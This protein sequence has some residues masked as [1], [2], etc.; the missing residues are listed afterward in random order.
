MTTRWPSTVVL[1]CALGLAGCGNTPAS[2]Q[3]QNP[4]PPAF[5]NVETAFQDQSLQDLATYA[6]SLV[7]AT[8]KGEKESREPGDV[9]HGEGYIGRTLTLAI[10]RTLWTQDGAPSVPEALDVLDWGWLVHEDK[11]VPVTAKGSPK[12][13]VG[14]TYLFALTSRDDKTVVMSSEATFLL[15][16]ENIVVSAGQD[17]PLGKQF[18]GR[19]AVDLAEAVRGTPFAAEALPYRHLPPYD[20]GKAVIAARNK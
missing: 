11:R 4:A 18:G 20:R 1:V 3:L 9:K 6:T 10:D 13:E 16:S 8:V 15:E 5:L 12:L 19:P 14:S 7:V 2:E 17:H